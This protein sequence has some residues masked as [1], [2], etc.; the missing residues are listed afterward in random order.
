VG[1]FYAHELIAQRDATMPKL[2]REH[3]AVVTVKLA[4]DYLDKLDT[5]ATRSH[6]SRADMIR[7]MIACAALTGQPDVRIDGPAHGGSDAA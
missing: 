2:S 1:F 5:M 7:A 4:A 3:L 6:R